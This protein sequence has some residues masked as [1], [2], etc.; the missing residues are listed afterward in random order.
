MN[1]QNIKEGMY[2]RGFGRRKGK[3]MGYNYTFYFS[4]IEKNNFYF[5]KIEKNPKLKSNS[6]FGSR[7][8]I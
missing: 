6:K 3:G 5:S 1:L 4:K 2:I 8:I 7:W